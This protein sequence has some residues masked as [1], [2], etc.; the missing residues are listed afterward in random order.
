MGNNKNRN[1]IQ[2]LSDGQM[3]ELM[4]GSAGRVDQSNL[5]S[6]A[7][8]ERGLIVSWMKRCAEILRA[9]GGDAEARAIVRAYKLIERG[10]H[11]NE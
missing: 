10:D 8:R 9:A 6:D 3:F 4:H 1:F 2:S 11:H 5:S 7:A